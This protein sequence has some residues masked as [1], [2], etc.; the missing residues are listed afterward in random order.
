MF[1]KRL[2]IPALAIAALMLAACGDSSST[3]ACQK[4]AYCYRTTVDT[5]RHCD[6]NKE[7]TEAKVQQAK[8][9]GIFKEEFEDCWDM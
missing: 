2:M 4:P 8:D 7:V 9:A 6:L 1:M 3:K 5:Q